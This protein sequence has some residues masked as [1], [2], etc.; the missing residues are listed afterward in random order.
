MH[1]L[2]VAVKLTAAPAVSRQKNAIVAG[3]REAQGMR[4][5]REGAVREGSALFAVIPACEISVRRYP[6][7][8]PR[9]VSGR[10]GYR[11][12]HGG[13]RRGRPI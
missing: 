10:L 4:Q 6:P 5:A 7:V 11:W 12:E 8:E 9:N 13:N 2:G 3:C 1:E